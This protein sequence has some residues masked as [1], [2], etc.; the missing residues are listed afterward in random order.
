MICT[1]EGCSTAIQSNTFVCPCHGSQ[2][3]SSGRVTQ[4]PANRNLPTYTVV[5]DPATDTLTIS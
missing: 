1:H 4:S 5:Y 2:F 3:D